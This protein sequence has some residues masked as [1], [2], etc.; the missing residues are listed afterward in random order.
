MV[1]KC[2]RE[3]NKKSR[4]SRGEISSFAC[5]GLILATLLPIGAA[6]AG[7]FSVLYSFQGGKDGSMPDGTLI[8]DPSGNLYGTTY[9]G[10]INRCRVTGYRC[11]TVFK[12]AAD[13]TEN[14]LYRF[15]GRD[16]GIGPV[17]GV[18]RDSSNNLYGTTSGGPFGEG[19]NGNV[20]EIASDGSETTLSSFPEGGG[21]PSD[22]LL[23]LNGALYGTAGTGG[24]GA[25]CTHGCGVLFKLTTGGAETV[26]HQFGNGNDGEYPAANVISDAS[27]NLFGTTFAGG[28]NGYGTVFKLTA[29]GTESVLYSFAGSNDGIFPYGGL[30][31]D[32]S[33]DLYGTTET[34]GGNGCFSGNGCGTV[35]EIAPDGSETVLYRFAGG[36]DGGNPYAGLIRDKAGNLYGTTFAG[37]GD[38]CQFGSGCGTVFEISAAG[39]EKILYAF[40]GKSDGANPYGGLLMKENA[41][42]GTTTG[43]GS[44]GNGVVFKIEK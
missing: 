34:G 37:G 21:D 8:A 33:G 16:N 15:T 28:A 30:V 19:T 10:G 5:C 11:G 3:G 39:V 6:H 27:G 25:N 24:T 12:L 32:P 13:G 7:G 44:T 18:I 17:G 26:L 42:Y 1:S 41:L 36:T 2:K 4:H 38:G 29:S 20:F 23:S 22:S 43:G 40:S 9:A 31:A 35:F 14:V